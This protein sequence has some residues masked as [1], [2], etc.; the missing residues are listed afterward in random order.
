MVQ[1]PLKLSL[2]DYSTWVSGELE[3]QLKP[4]EFKARSLADESQKAFGEA[5]RFFEDLSRKAEKDMA[6]KRDPISYRAARVIGHAAKEAS[7]SLSLIQLPRD[8]TWDSLRSFKDSASTVIRTLRELRSRASRELSGLY[9][10]DMRSFSGVSERIA[11]ANERL[12]RFLEGDG[13]NLLRARTLAGILTSIEEVRRELKEKEDEAKRLTLETQALSSAVSDVSGEIEKLNGDN[14]LREVLETER[15]LRRESQRFR[16]ITLAH[17]KRPLRKMRD[18]AERG[19]IPLGREERQALALYIQSPYRSFLSKTAGPYLTDILQH[20]K[21]SLESG[22]M[23]FKP[24][25]AAR[26]LTQL[27]QLLAAE[28]LSAQQ[29]KGR[30]LLSRR[31]KL[32]RDPNCGILYKGRKSMMLKLDEAHERQEEL[33]DRTRTV[34]E[35]S[36]VLQKRI[37]D[38]LYQAE[39]KTKEYIG[40]DVEIGRSQASPKHG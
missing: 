27:Q 12:T 24:R 33:L 30:E 22:K 40:R 7:R 2:E 36:E 37:S 23:E 28:H 1:S 6:N 17:L 16:T 4:I 13:S 29:K 25:K 18:L 3:K 38:L 11:K 39:V 26:V 10:L 20:L 31:A 8:T 19:D 21:T 9:I 34:E 35:K 32:L 15:E 14:L 5:T